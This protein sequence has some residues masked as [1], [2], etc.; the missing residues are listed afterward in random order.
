MGR[1]RNLVGRVMCCRCDRPRSERLLSAHRCRSS[2]AQRESALRP[3]VS[4]CMWDG[5][6]LSFGC[7]PCVRTLLDF[8]GPFRT[9][10]V[11]LALRLSQRARLYNGNSN[12]KTPPIF[13]KS[14]SEDPHPLNFS[15]NPQPHP[16]PRC[17]KTLPPCQPSD[18]SG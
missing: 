16:R 2:K 15:E 9:P 3:C 10:N 13:L 1:G 6:N 4:G 14:I 8:S 18:V 11:F 5:Y 12:S 7:S 17:Q